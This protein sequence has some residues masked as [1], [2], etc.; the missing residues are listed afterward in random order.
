MNHAFAT[1]R[2]PRPNRIGILSFDDVPLYDLGVQ[3]KVVAT[4]IQGDGSP[5]AQAMWE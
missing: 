3:L 4:D 1:A 2:W 5:L